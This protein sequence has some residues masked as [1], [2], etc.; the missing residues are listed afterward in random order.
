MTS[1][2]SDGAGSFAKNAA[3]E[4]WLP[5]GSVD[6]DGEDEEGSNDGKNEASGDHFDDG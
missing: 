4:G 1:L 2:T 3:I 5:V 6:A